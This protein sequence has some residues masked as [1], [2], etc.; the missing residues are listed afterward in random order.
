M[1][2]PTDLRYTDDH[3][4]I[5]LNGSTAR[6][7]ITDHAQKQLGDIVFFEAPQLGKSLDAGE[8]FGA[9]ESVKAWNS[10]YMPVTGEVVRVNDAAKDSPELLN[11]EPYGDGW[12]IEIRCR[13]SAAVDKLM[14]AQQ[15]E[16]YITPEE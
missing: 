8:E 15:Y 16:A 10:L 14:T 11:E 7:G 9:V 13:D 4:W 6:V 1:D 5:R 3:E 12:L 2:N